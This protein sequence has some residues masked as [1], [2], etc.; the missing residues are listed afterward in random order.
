MFSR[1]KYPVESKERKRALLTQRAGLRLG[2]ATAAGLASDRK[3]LTHTGCVYDGDDEEDEDG[4]DGEVTAGFEEIKWNT[5]CCGPIQTTEEEEEEEE[6]EPR[7]NGVWWLLWTH[8][9]DP[10][11]QV[12][13]LPHPGL[14]L[15]LHLFLQRQSNTF[16]TRSGLHPPARHPREATPTSSSSSRRSAS[17][18][19]FTCCVVKVTKAV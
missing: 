11:Q 5:T 9:L 6:E 4:D 15:L 10:A 3:A 18:M 8:A 17:L 16:T 13:D 1:H 2:R 19:Y 12:R 14:L 7:L